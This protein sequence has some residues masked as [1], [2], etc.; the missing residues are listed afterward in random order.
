[1][2]FH[3]TLTS[4]DYPEDAGSEHIHIVSNLLPVYVESY[5]RIPKCLSEC[6]DNL[7]L[8]SVSFLCV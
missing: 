5:P 1:M 8:C 3:S 2:Y 7:E 4:F 6:C